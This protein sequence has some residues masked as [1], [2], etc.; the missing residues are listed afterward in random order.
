MP[1]GKHPLSERRPGGLRLP[2]TKVDG[3]GI[4]HAVR[5]C[6]EPLVFISARHRISLATP[7]RF[8]AS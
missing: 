4:Y 5:G 8:I 6:G 7:P 2:K 3:I 1:I